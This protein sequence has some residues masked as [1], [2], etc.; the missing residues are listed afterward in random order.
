M[1]ASIAEAKDSYIRNDYSKYNSLFSYVDYCATQL[2]D[3][4]SKER[5][6]D[7]NEYKEAIINTS[8]SYISENEY[9]EFENELVSQIRNQLN[10]I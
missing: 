1:K 6:N 9:P 2:I 3:T 5:L 7:Y 10:D 8:S 4:I